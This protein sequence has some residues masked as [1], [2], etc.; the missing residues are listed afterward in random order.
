[1]LIIL[2]GV[3]RVGKSTIATRL[4]NVLN[5][6]IFHPLKPFKPTEVHIRQIEGE[7]YAI[8]KLNIL[9]KFNLICDRFHYSQY[10][11]PKVKCQYDEW[12]EKMFYDIEKLLESKAVVFYLYG[13]IGTILKRI[14]AEETDFELERKK[15][16]EYFN[17][18]EEVF[19]KSK[20]DIIKLDTTKLTLEETAEKIQTW[21]RA[22]LIY[23]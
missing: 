9:M 17:Y 22:Y 23:D 20:L 21:L 11:Y 8:A 19:T 7:Y 12:I 3:D 10:V 5:I 14:N 2:E 13:D 16:N 1:M 6:P 15:I 18:Y 4:S